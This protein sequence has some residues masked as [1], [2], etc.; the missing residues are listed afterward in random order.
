MI[1]LKTDAW[2][3]SHAYRYMPVHMYRLVLSRS[4]FGCLDAYKNEF[5]IF[6]IK[7][8]KYKTERKY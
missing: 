4:G 2:A 5:C 1:I 8:F 6:Y 3:Y 7:Y